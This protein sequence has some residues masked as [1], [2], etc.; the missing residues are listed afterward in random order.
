[1]L[2]REG[3]K[4]V[5]KVEKVVTEKPGD[6]GSVDNGV[7]GGDDDGGRW[8]MRAG[9]GGQRGENVED[10]GRVAPTTTTGGGTLTA[11]KEGESP[12][13]RHATG[14]QVTFRS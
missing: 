7:D 5:D 12:H 11:Y 2:V 14:T 9:R 10:K 3:S 13:N 8:W 4:V 1:M 6:Q